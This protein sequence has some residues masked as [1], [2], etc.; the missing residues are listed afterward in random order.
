MSLN[1]TPSEV[2]AD[3]YSSIFAHEREKTYPMVD[4]FEGRMGYHIDTERVEEA[5]RVLSCPFKAAAPNWQHGRVLYAATRRYL[6]GLPYQDEGP[7]QIRTLDIGTA[8]G[9]SALCVRF[10]VEDAGVDAQSVSVDVLPPDARVRRNT[11]AEVDG[12]KTL[13][14]I[15]A[16]WPEAS[17]I[18]FLNMTGVDFL[19]G[20]AL[21]IHVAFVDGKHS[22]AVVKQEG[23][24]LADVQQPGDL[25]IFDD[26]HIPDVGAA[27]DALAKLYDIERLQ[28][29]PKRAYAIARRK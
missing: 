16:P 13:A 15:L 6:A 22:G 26:V 2:S 5:A 25:A 20:N 21:R 28:I 4:A 18:T 24:M 14:E 19:K 11:P 17:R 8:K 7:P 23:L 29:L 27:V 3:T 10:A 9:Y 12:L 1:Y